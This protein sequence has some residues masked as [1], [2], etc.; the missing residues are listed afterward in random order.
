VPSARQ[1]RKLALSLPESEERMTW[2]Q[3]TFRVRNRMFAI[4]SSDGARASIKASR[5]AQAALIGSDPE[6]FFHPAYVGVHGWVGLRLAL[7]DAAELRELVIE[8]WLLTAPKR[9]AANLAIDS[10]R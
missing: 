4:L 9:L 3:S 7:V 8:A 2:G 10:I 5:E 6:V 1:F